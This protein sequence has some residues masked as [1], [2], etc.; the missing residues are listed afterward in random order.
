MI[1]LQKEMLTKNT[2]K[3][4][5][6]DTIDRWKNMNGDIIGQARTCGLSKSSGI[7]I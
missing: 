6:L 5:Y 7:H 3:M 1:I 2:E 4:V